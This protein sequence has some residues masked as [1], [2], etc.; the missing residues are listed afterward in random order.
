MQNAL[1]SQGI[2]LESWAPF[3]Q[4]KNNLFNQE[5]LVALSSKYHKNIA[6]VVL[7]WL[8]QRKVVLI[9]KLTNMERTNENFNVFD[10]G[11]SG[12]DLTAIKSLDEGSGLIYSV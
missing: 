6:Q 11:L 7:R 10:F 9:P 8:I 2:Q 12:D 1:K 3:A 5:L 4:G